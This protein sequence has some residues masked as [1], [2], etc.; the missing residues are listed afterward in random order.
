MR[1]HTLTE[2]RRVLQV[3]ARMCTVHM[4]CVRT[5]EHERANR[6]ARPHAGRACLQAHKRPNVRNACLQT[7]TP[8]CTLHAIFQHNTRLCF[9]GRLQAHAQGARNTRLFFWSHSHYLASHPV[10]L[11]IHIKMHFYA[12]L[13]AFFL[14]SHV[15]NFFRIM[16]ILRRKLINIF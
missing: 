12:L 10:P 4:R 9:I 14:N 5:H 2:A 7:C 6:H 16:N 1:S 15:Q 11:H 3:P 8:V 13:L